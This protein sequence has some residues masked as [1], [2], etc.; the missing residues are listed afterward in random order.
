MRGDGRSKAPRRAILAISH[1]VDEAA[2]LG[3][4]DG[5]DIADLVGEALTRPIAVLGRRKQGAEKE[6][7]PIGV[8]MI[9]ADHLGDEITRVPAD[10]IHV[11]RV[12]EA[13]AVRPDDAEADSRLAHRIEREGR[14]EE[15]QKWPDSAARIVVFGLGQQQ[16]RTAFDVAQV[17]VVTQG[18]ADDAA[19]GGHREH[20]FRLRIVPGRHRVKSGIHPGADGGHRLRLGEDFRIR[21]DA[22]LEILAPHVLCDQRFLERAASFEPG[23][24]CL[25]SPI[26]TI[27]RM[28]WRMPSAA[29]GLPRAR[30]SITRSIIEIGEGDTRRLDRLKI[31][32]REQPRL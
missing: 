19:V 5:D 7:R 13:K 4:G 24:R 9:R 10:P 23:R 29:C 15:A 16:R 8:L 26:P 20:H 14:I 30:S 21:P 1:A 3:G 6:H 11:G 17:D 2:E 31:D 28:S 25:R 18:S 32:G 22:D 27:R 12:V